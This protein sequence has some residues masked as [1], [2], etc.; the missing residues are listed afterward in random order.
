MGWTYTHINRGEAY[1]N[2]KDIYTMENERI[3]SEVLRC[4][5][6]G[7]TTF[8]AAVKYTYKETGKSFV[9]AGVCKTHFGRGQWNFG[10]KEM[11]EFMGPSESDCPETIMKMLTPLDEIAEIENYDKTKDGSYTFAKR[12]RENCWQ[13]INGKKQLVNG[14]IVKAKTPIPFRDGSKIDTFEVKRD[15]KRVRFLSFNVETGKAS[16]YGWY[17]LSK[18]AMADLEVIALPLPVP[19]AA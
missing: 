17:K 3:K 2:L 5:L 9:Y 12:W 16:P 19:K 7:F 13:L 1:K 6:K 15:R 10:Y 8:Y 11:E 14:A 4:F 18:W